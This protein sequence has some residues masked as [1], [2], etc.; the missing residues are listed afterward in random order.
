MR[1]APAHERAGSQAPHIPPRPTRRSGRDGASHRGRHF[2]LV[3]EARFD[4]YDG[5]AERGVAF[6]RRQA[7]KAKRLRVTRAP[8]TREAILV[9]A[10]VGRVG[11]TSLG[12][13]QR[14]RDEREALLAEVV[15]TM[16]AISVTGPTSFDP[17]FRAHSGES[18]EF[19]LEPP[20][21]LNPSLAFHRS[22]EAWPSHENQG[23][24]VARTRMVDFLVDA[25]RMGVR[26]RAFTHPDAN[27]KA[28]LHTLA[29]VY[30]REAFA[31]DALVSS[32]TSLDSKTFDAELSRRDAI[33]GSRT[34]N[35]VLTYAKSHAKAAY[36]CP[37][38][39]PGQERHHGRAFISRVAILVDP[40]VR[41]RGFHDC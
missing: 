40:L 29:I 4:L 20:R 8:S 22:V 28:T 31:G 25:Y 5:L 38:C 36:R 23:A 16:V 6:P 9:D 34:S 19:A 7:V 12:I 41:P 15:T 33:V 2:A 37:E 26:A 11:R 3:D 10:H 14:V 30:E 32:V 18:P 24:H 21:P 35:D 13:V 39:V 17:A 1:Y 27:E